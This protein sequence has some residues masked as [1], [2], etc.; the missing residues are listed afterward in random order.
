M[1][2]GYNF[3]PRRRNR[4]GTLSTWHSEPYICVMADYPLS[5]D[6]SPNIGSFSNSYARLPAAFY[7]HAVPAKVT[8][9]RLIKFNEALA[10]ELGLTPP[11]QQ[12]AAIF[13]GNLIPAGAE[14]LAMAYAG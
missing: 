4:A 6:L 3:R 11:P 12:R 13:A 14:P 10:A 8:E 5:E 2:R 1:H 7:A 9:P